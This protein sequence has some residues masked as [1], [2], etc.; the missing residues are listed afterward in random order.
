[1]ATMNNQADISGF[2]SALAQ[3]NPQFEPVALSNRAL[4][5]VAFYDFAFHEYLLPTETN[6]HLLPEQALAYIDRLQQRGAP[7]E[8]V[9]KFVPFLKKFN[10][11]LQKAVFDS[12]AQSGQ[13]HIMLR[14]KQSLFDRYFTEREYETHSLL[15]RYHSE[16][17]RGHN[18]LELDSALYHTLLYK[19]YEPTAILSNYFSYL[20]SPNLIGSTKFYSFEVPA[21]Y[22]S[23]DVFPTNSVNVGLRLIY[24]QEWK[25]L[26]VQPGEIV[27]TIPLGPGQKERITTKIIRRQKTTST[28][29]IVT[30][31]ET[32]T[33]TTDTTK[34]SSEIVRERASEW[35]NERTEQGK[36][37]ASF[38]ILGFFGGGG[39]YS[40]GSV[41]TDSTSNK[42]KKT[43]SNLSESMQKTAS[44]MRTQ[45][46]VVVSTE[47]EKSFEQETYSEISNPN[48]EV[49]ITYEYHKLQ[50]QYEVFTYLAEAQ[51]VIFVAED[52]PP[53]AEVNEDWVRKHDWIIAKILK[54]ESYRATLNE[55]IQDVDE[56]DPIKEGDPDP[57]ALMLTAATTNFASF[58]PN[59]GAPG[60][61][62]SVPDIYAEPQR[63]YQQNLRDNAARKRANAIRDIKRQRL[64]QHIRDNILYYCRAIWAHEDSDQR[65]LRYKKENRRV[66][67]EW[68]LGSQP[69]QSALSWIPTGKDAPLWELID[70]TGPS[71]FA[72]NY[73]VFGLR[74]LPETDAT[75]NQP[76][77]PID[78]KAVL[79]IMRD[80]YVGNDGTLLDPA[81]ASYRSEAADIA[82]IN[83]AVLKPTGDAAVDVLSYLPRLGKKILDDNGNLIGF[84]T[85]QLERDLTTEEYGE[86]LYKKNGTR[87]FLVDSNNLYLSIRTGEGAALEPFKRAHRYIDVLKANEELNAMNLK[88]Q[89]REEH[90]KTAHEYDPDIEKVIIVGDNAIAENAALHEA[91]ELRVRRASVSSETTDAESTSSSGTP[92]PDGGRSS[93][94]RDG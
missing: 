20:L 64:Y 76:N 86:Y 29:E 48:N 92:L 91:E 60:G 28:M 11:F 9:Q 68:A 55:L 36:V 78:L 24:R 77:Q 18:K 69:G 88:N 33:E 89:R 90:L 42:S 54:E 1:M 53:P 12:C 65:I 71:G 32:T 44:K 39:E 46:K 52:V 82:N 61:G 16:Q 8:L 57:S 79:S 23:F 59:T 17:M 94:R 87:R 38:D 73:A 7:S 66:P 45:T 15:S 4:D 50:Q 40:Q 13:T 43:S 85:E 26:G 25:P 56:I 74:P 21:E 63:I 14:L 67:I 62:L 84:S 35:K 51:S 75:A 70:P 19:M 37:E 6:H 41:T 2:S 47:S 34:D 80:P 58:H 72:G 27:R 22:E 31:T 10:V 30:E 83:P 49:A 81:L 93:D 3:L 5:N